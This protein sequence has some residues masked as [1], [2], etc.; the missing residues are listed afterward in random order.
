MHRGGITR[1][2]SSLQ[3]SLKPSTTLFTNLEKCSRNFNLGVKDLGT[4]CNFGIRK[5]LT[6]VVLSSRSQFCL[7][8]PNPD[9]NFEISFAFATFSIKLGTVYFRTFFDL[10]R[11]VLLRRVQ[12]LKVLSFYTA[13][14]KPPPQ[15][16]K[17]RS[18]PKK[19]SATLHSRIH[20][21]CIG[22]SVITPLYFNVLL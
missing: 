15:T 4:M 1:Y 2:N 14:A 7:P 9:T 22:G 13:G 10:F 19:G 6:S 18:R 21:H 20:G 3:V 11:T 8:A 5:L 12:F 16:S 17:D